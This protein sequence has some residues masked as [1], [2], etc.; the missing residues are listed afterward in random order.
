[1]PQL[2]PSGSPLP[3]SRHRE[4]SASCA[5][6]RYQP[7]P[8]PRSTPHRASCSGT[9]STDSRGP[10]IQKRNIELNAA[11]VQLLLTAPR[12]SRYSLF[13][14]S[15]RGPPVATAISGSDLRR[16]A[17]CSHH[18]SRLTSSPADAK[19]GGRAAHD[20][21]QTRVGEAAPCVPQMQD[22]T[23]S[24]QSLDNGRRHARRYT[25]TSQRQQRT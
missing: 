14:S 16:S 25:R 17:D 12:S 15:M 1:M 2:Q 9:P 23:L 22:T 18:R 10:E 4:P 20:P 8:S 5:A 21:R 13:T 6:V 24:K 7:R 11:L 3:A 19:D